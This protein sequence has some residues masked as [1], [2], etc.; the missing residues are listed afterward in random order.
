MLRNN[1]MRKQNKIK[2]FKINR[3][4]ENSRLESN[5]LENN[6]LEINNYCSNSNN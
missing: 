4:L 5:K 2:C 1:K 6:K 3:E